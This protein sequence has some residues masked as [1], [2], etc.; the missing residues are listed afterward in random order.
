MD[1]QTL[2]DRNIGLLGLDAT[3]VRSGV[4]SFDQ[5]RSHLLPELP[6]VLQ[7]FARRETDH[8]IVSMDG[9]SLIVFGADEGGIFVCDMAG[10]AISYLR[11]DPMSAHEQANTTF[12][13]F[14]RCIYFFQAAVLEASAHIQKLALI[15]YKTLQ[16]GATIS[17]SKGDREVFA[18]LVSRLARRGEAFVRDLE[19]ADLP[20][21]WAQLW[22]Q[23]EDGYFSFG[24]G[25]MQMVRDGLMTFDEAA[26]RS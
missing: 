19:G 2:L 4:V 3:R 11:H 23:F 14:V 22:Y 18:S 10:D 7:R 6:I 25:L 26:Q 12:G 17:E 9:K 20:P 1:F 21:Y 13:A 8:H 5:R 15:D 24:Y 16:G